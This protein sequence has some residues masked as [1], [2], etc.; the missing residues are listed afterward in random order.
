MKNH[1]NLKVWQLSKD[2]AVD[3]YLL[4]ENSSGFKDFRFR[5]QI[6]SSAVSIP[7]NIAEG[8]E[9]GTL[10]H[11]INHLHIAKGSC[12]ELQTQLIIAMEVKKIEP[13][14]AEK[15]IDKCEIISIM[16]YKL[17]QARKK[18]IKNSK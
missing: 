6:I 4:I 11:G 14:V 3:V 1:K 18:F 15:L 2:L 9:L 12:A 16:I 7:S 10:K 5:A 8:N 13:S 17:I